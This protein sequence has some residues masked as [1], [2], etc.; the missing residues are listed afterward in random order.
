MKK[1][2]QMMYEI[3]LNSRKFRVIITKKKIKKI[4]IRLN[5][6]LEILV[7]SP[8]FISYSDALNYIFQ[9]AEWLE[10][11]INKYDLIIKEFSVNER[12]EERRVG[13]ECRSR[14]SPY[15]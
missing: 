4:I 15:H 9:N 11:I 12:S 5:Y 10:K 13:K 8:L 6:R 2:N 1:K 3:N 14:W 7:S